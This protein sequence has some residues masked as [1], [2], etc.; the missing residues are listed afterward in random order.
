MNDAFPASRPSRLGRLQLICVAQQ[1]RDFSPR[2]LLV[3]PGADPS[4]WT[5]IG[6]REVSIRFCANHE[7]LRDVRR[8][9]PDTFAALAVMGARARVHR[10]ELVAYAK[11]GLAPRFHFVRLRK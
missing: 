11:R 2:R 7:I 9:D 4:A 3:E 5:D 1:L 8:G 6:R 10:E